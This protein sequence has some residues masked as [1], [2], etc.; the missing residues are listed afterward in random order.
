L[1][2]SG[3][4]RGRWFAPTW[5][6]YHGSSGCP[7][8][9][10]RKHPWRK[11]PFDPADRHR[12]TTE[13]PRLSHYLKE[14]CV[15]RPVSVHD[16]AGWPLVGRLACHS[17]A[18]PLDSLGFRALS[19]LSQQ[20]RESNGVLVQDDVITKNGRRGDGHPLPSTR[21]GRGTW[22]SSVFCEA[23]VY[24]VAFERPRGPAGALQKRGLSAFGR[25]QS[26]FRA[27][28]ADAGEFVWWWPPAA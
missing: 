22:R 27:A 20:S 9:S 23:R 19:S 26:S 8:R 3:R 10:G 1:R 14:G 18:A 5:N 6:V 11:Q 28:C 4:A 16:A 13:T 12:P 2:P 21:R 15:G 7:S 24:G 25:L 17:A